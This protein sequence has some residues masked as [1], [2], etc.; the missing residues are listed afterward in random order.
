MKTIGIFYGSSTGT[1]E[2]VAKRIAQKLGVEDAHL[3][4]VAK[5]SPAD[6]ASYEVLILGSS[7]WGAGDL[8]DDWYDFL[9]KIKKLDLTGKTVAIFG[10]GDSSS[11][12]DTFCDAIGIIYTD[13]QGTGCRFIGSVPTDGYTYDD[14]TAVIDGQFVGLPLDEMNEDD[15]TTAR[16][17][18][19]ID[20]LKKEGLE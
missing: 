8:Q 1:T 10:C 15:Q 5:A 3:Y 18:Q 12:A 2:S 7:T 4:D 13:L 16:L 14:S 6:M 20:S 17:D 19:W 9:A 11:F